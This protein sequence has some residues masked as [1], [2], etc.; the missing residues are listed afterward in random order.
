M[1]RRSDP[2]G[3]L[4]RGAMFLLMFA[5]SAVAYKVTRSGTRIPRSSLGRE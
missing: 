1:A 5:E 4:C 2:P 3:S